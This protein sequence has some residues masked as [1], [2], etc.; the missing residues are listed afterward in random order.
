M[1]ICSMKWSKS[2]LCVT[3]GLIC[4]YAS[5]QGLKFHGTEVDIDDRTSLELFPKRY[6]VFQDCLSISFNVYSTPVSRFGYVFRLYDRNNPGKVWNLSL[7]TRGDKSAM[8]LNE[9]GEK[10]IIRAEFPDRAS[11]DYIWTPVRIVFDLSGMQVSMKVGGFCDSVSYAFPE[12]KFSPALVFGRCDNVAD[13][14]SFAISDLIISDFRRTFSIPLDEYAGEQ[15]H[16]GEGVK[17]GAVA[18]PQWINCDASE[19]KLICTMASSSPAGVFYDRQT[20]RVCLYNADSLRYYSFRSNKERE[21]STVNS[22]P[23][24]LLQGTNFMIGR[25]LYAY[26]TYDWQKGNVG[27]AIAFLD[28]DKYYWESVSRSRLPSIMRHHAMFMIDGKVPAIFG[29]AND[30]SYSS[31]ISVLDDNFNWS[32]K[33]MG[34]NLPVSPRCFASAGTDE[35]GRFAYLFGGIGNESGEQGVGKKYYY[36]LYKLDTYT[37]GMVKLWSRDTE[38]DDFVPGRNL[39]VDNGNIYVLSY[40]EYRS[41]TDIQLL[42]L[43]ID[44]GSCCR[45]ADRLRGTNDNPYNYVS[46][47]LDKGIGRFIATVVEMDED[48][49]PTVRVYSLLYPASPFIADKGNK[50]M[51]ILLI[52][53]FSS[54]LI[55][56]SVWYISKRSRGRKMAEISY[57]NSLVD[58]K[59]KKY[60]QDVRANAIFL[61]GSFVITDREGNDIAS[62]LTIQQKNILILL[63]LH[64]EKGLPS[65]RIGN[66][67]WPDKESERAKNCRCVAINSLRKSLAQTQGCGIGFRNGRY[68]MDLT[69]ECYCDIYRLEALQIKGTCQEALDILSRGQFMKELNDPLFDS[70]KEK[71][72]DM[73]LTFLSDAMT[74]MSTNNNYQAVIEIANMIFNYDPLDEDALHSQIRALLSIHRRED[75]IVRYAA[76]CNEYTK[77][78]GVEYPFTFDK[79]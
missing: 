16:D 72:S 24:H 60:H 50:L 61:F 20:K 59:K 25:K 70:F 55:L 14:P 73:A 7:D 75:A 78:N 35:S 6:P 13:V 39:I 34:R 22:C 53:L 30:Q 12:K 3:L 43:N 15:V 21:R 57:A 42:R 17:I 36:D 40:P 47:Y 27:D 19:W 68:F 76:F 63:L 37:G 79:I 2:I 9:E 44:D 48:L 69:D 23:V 38:R 5:A 1:Y 52:A 46:L 56:I 54:I 66:L 58:P 8:L 10:N 29:G 33:W 11:L 32:C 77:T 45:L 67:I 41:K 62:Q 49:C 64:G 71:V 28:L 51:V 65:E 31:D 4:G 74:S 26:E 18:N